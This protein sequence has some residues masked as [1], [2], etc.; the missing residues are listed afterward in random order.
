MLL[1]WLISTIGF[2]ALKD[3]LR[4]TAR[5]AMFAAI[6]IVLW[7]VALGFAIAALTAWLST[8]VGPI[9]ACGIIAGVFAVIALIIQVSLAVT[10][11]KRASPAPIAAGLTAGAALPEM[12]SVAA[13]TG[14]ALAA[15]FLGRQ[16]FRR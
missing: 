3:E 1:R 4:R 6:A 9:A 15:F 12:G 11:R 13:L 8:L 10:K 7:V 16:Y 2:A 5:R 14:A